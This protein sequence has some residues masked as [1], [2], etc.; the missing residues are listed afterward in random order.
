MEVD[1]LYEFDAPKIYDFQDPDAYD[2]DLD[3]WFGR[4][5]MT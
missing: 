2:K 1:P 5:Q 3:V 4:L